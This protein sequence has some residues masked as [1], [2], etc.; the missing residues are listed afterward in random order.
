[1][2]EFGTDSFLARPRRKMFPANS[3][4]KK[5]GDGHLFWEC[6]FHP[7]EHVRDLPEFAT[8]MS[9]NRS[10]WPR[11]LLWHGWLPGLGCSGDRAP[12]AASFGQL[13]CLKLEVC[14][15]AYPV[16]F[17][18]CWAPL[19][20][21]DADDIALEMSDYPNIWTD[22]SREDFSSVGGFEV[23]LALVF[24]CLHLLLLLIPWYG[25]LQKSMVMLI[26]SVAVL[27]C[28]FQVLCRLFTVLNYGVLFLPCRRI[29][30]VT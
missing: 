4:A 10:N 29:G 24:I 9:L 2:E 20:Y 14:L 5:D 26:W 7:P 13:A 23:L 19:E 17:S 22:G 11:C 28:L 21:W 25:E 8:L 12:W 16:D 15:G 27:F 3:V 30:L 1:M 6:T 18:S